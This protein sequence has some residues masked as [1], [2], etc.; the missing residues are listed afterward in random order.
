MMTSTVQ[1]AQFGARS[2]IQRPGKA[3]HALRVGSSSRAFAQQHTTRYFSS[4]ATTAK[5]ASSKTNFALGVTGGLLL[6]G[7][8]SATGSSND[9]Y[10]YRFKTNKSPDDLASF[11]GGEEFMELFCIFPF[12]GQIMMRNGEF[13]D[14]G[15]VYT[16]GIPGTMKVS[17]V[18]SD[19]VDQATGETEWFN[20]R[21]RFQDTCWGYTCWDMVSNFGFRTL[22]DGTIEAYHYGEYFHGNLP[23][24]SQI[25]KT[26]FQ[27]H[28]RWLAWS[29]EHHINHY[30]FTADSDEEE[31]LEEESRRNMPLFLLKNYAWS[32]IMAMVFGVKE[33]VEHKKSPSFLVRRPS[34]DAVD[35]EKL[36][37][38]RKAMKLQISQD[39]ASDREFSKQ[40]LARSSTQTQDDV[41]AV[42]ARSYSL[43]KMDTNKQGNAYGYAT[44][45]AR[46]RHMTRRDSLKRMATADN[47]QNMKP[48]RTQSVDK[49]VSSGVKPAPEEGDSNLKRQPSSIGA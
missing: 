9:F 16:T 28:A 18:F 41:K 22:E 47:N 32:D 14:E 7:L 29:T 5:P 6:A 17:M 24:V 13:D 10:E 40:M 35:G 20:K 48:T 34:E 19:D 4:V 12:V 37:M 26:V 36:A 42:L 30:A 38:Q 31:E 3:T 8:H 49:D 23:V 27:V 25:M 33:D 15:N 43:K 45:A 21:E 46:Q 39:I 11:Y 1:A 2:L 44:E